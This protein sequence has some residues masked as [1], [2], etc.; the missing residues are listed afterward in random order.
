MSENNQQTKVNILK[1]IPIVS[2][3]KSGDPTIN[4][5]WVSRLTDINI[6]TT[7]NITEDFMKICIINKKRIFLHVVI[8]GMGGTQFEP[9]I[10]NV[11]TTFYN[12]AKLIESG[13]PQNQVLVIV[14]PIIQNMNGLKAIQ[15]LLKIF[16]KFKELRLRYVRFELLKYFNL[17]NSERSDTWIIANRNINGRYD[18]KLLEPFWKQ[19]YQA[20]NREFK[21]L[22]KHYE[23]IIT[24]D[25]AD[26]PLIGTRELKPFGYINHYKDSNGKQDSI[27]KYKDNDKSKPILN[28]ISKQPEHR[29]INKCLLCPYK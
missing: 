20:F 18:V 6:I 1:P 4:F 22:I 21:Q 11:Q 17:K 12:L 9:N 29:C 13:F 16:S 2:W 3:F 8:N 23:T 15:L 28:I 27:V 19:D 7:K 5:G 24:I 14:K 26:E 25:E 10:D